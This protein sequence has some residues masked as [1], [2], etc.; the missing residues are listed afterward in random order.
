MN[1][2][3]GAPVA[4]ERMASLTEM[5]SAQTQ[6]AYEAAA[7]YA[8]GAVPRGVRQR[9]MIAGMR[10]IAM[11]NFDVLMEFELTVLPDGLPPYPARAQQL[12]GAWQARRLG[13][14]LTLDVCAD[15]ANPAAVWLWLED[16]A[17]Q[18]LA[19]QGRAGQGRAG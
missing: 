1:A 10:Q 19:G 4:Q 9:A 16:P 5:L 12:V 17:G 13:P 3:C 7:S 8:N 14:G 18:S 11:V 6:A 15:P 2:V